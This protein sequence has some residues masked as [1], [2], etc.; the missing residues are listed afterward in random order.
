ME[1]HFEMAFRRNC[2]WFNMPNNHSFN[3]CNVCVV[4]ISLQ[5]WTRDILLFQGQYANQ[6]NVYA[7]RI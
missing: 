3:V 7:A 6:R 2:D 4:T 1:V 5:N